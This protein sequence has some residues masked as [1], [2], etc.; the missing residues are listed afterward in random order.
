MKGQLQ[1]VG[2]VKIMDMRRLGH[3]GTEISEEVI[4]VDQAWLKIVGIIAAGTEKIEERHIWK[5]RQASWGQENVI[6]K[7]VRKKKVSEI[8]W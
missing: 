1:G 6:I 7:G 3:S 2:F 8:F 4:R 5:R